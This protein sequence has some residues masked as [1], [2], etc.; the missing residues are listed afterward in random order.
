M[1]VNIALSH[2][3]PSLNVFENST[4]ML[5][6]ISLAQEND[7]LVMPEGCLSGYSH[8]LDF[9]CD[10][11]DVDIER[12]IL[13]LE[14]A[15]IKYKVH[16]IFGSLIKE[17]NRWFN[18]GILISFRGNKQIYKKVNLAMHERGILHKGNELPV[19]CLDINGREMKVAVQLCR[20]IRF[21]EQWKFLS[22]N[23]S[24]IIFYLTN[25]SGSEKLPVWDSHLISRAAENQR[26]I[27]SSNISHPEQGC[28]SMIVSPDGGIVKRLNGNEEAIESIQIN[29]ESNSNWYLSQSRVDLVKVGKIVDV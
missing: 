10:T 15:A 26:Y 27:V 28:S 22:M 7:I 8:N 13:E 24:E 17:Q 6:L 16:L 19:F 9:L 4:K 20:E 1:K 14:K 11:R 25:V 5:K 12:A 23:G 29:L 18:A 21:P 3:R 2:F